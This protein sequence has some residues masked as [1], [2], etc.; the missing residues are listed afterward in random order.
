M[1]IN[2]VE[3][4]LNTSHEN[5]MSITATVLKQTIKETNNIDTETRDLIYLSFT[6][7]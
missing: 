6:H 7:I 4:G 5:L 3:F 2:F 1:R